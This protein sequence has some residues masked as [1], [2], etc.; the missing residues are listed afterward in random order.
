MILRLNRNGQPVLLH[1]ISAYERRSDHDA[2][3]LSSIGSVST[4]GWSAWEL[5]HWRGARPVLARVFYAWRGRSHLRELRAVSAE[6][7][8]LRRRLLH[9]A[10]QRL[11][12]WRLAQVLRCWGETTRL[13][14]WGRL[15]LA[16]AVDRLSM[17]RLHW[18][19][20]VWHVAAGCVCCVLSLSVSL[21]I[22][23]S[24]SLSL[25]SSS[26]SSSRTLFFSLS[27][28]ECVHAVAPRRKRRQ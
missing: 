20:A 26:S 27:L 3:A 24:L 7:R 15:R 1:L 2:D 5:E 23:L 22:S 6:S 9:S 18:A 28:S 12:R 4:A 8:E 16:R 19:M 11:W 13:L 17:L 21:C 10:R 14:T 25:F